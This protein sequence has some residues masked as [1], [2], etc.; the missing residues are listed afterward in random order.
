MVDE[1]IVGDLERRERS[2]EENVVSHGRDTLSEKLE[3]EAAC[4]TPMTRIKV[5]ITV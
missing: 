3:D 5:F 1:T 4:V 2:R